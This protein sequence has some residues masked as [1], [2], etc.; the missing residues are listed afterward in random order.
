[1]KS[2][3][4]NLLKI[5][6]RKNTEV[7]KDTNKILKNITLFGSCRINGITNNN[8]LNNLINYTH[9]T[10][11]VLQQIQFLLGNISFPA[12]FNILC[13][14]TG[15]VENKPI[16]YNS[17]FNTLFNNSK[18]CV[19]EICSD[20]KYMHD[21]YYLHHLCVD[22]RTPSRHNNTPKNILDNFKCIK[23]TYTEIENDILEIK[24]LLEPRKIIL[25]THY[26]SKIN[27]EYIESRNNLII[28][29]SEICEKYNIP[30][31]KPSEVLKD[32]IQEDVMTSDLGH[33][34]SL[35]LS[36]FSEYINN[37]LNNYK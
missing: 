27:N 6:I 7:N 22:K 28:M 4:N 25:V 10:K 1:M 34:T 17:K 35:G 11:E 16:L 23:Q 20:K 29:L 21:N 18:V 15:I 12:P 24:T 2:K 9:S 19:I 3:K 14:R 30:I 26:N 32:Y 36:K 5:L 31:I 33:Y 13:F 37:Y 8:N